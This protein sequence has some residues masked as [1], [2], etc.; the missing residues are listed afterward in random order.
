MIIGLDFDNTIV[1]YDEAIARLADELL[2]LPETVPRTKLGVREHF[3]DRGREDEWTAF[4][5]VLYGPGM[6]HAQPFAGCLETLKGLTAK[7]YSLSIV[8]HRSARPY[9]GPAYDLHDYARNWVSRH[10]LEDGLI[11]ADAVFFH[12]TRE[13][14]VAQIGQLGCVLFLDDLPE[15]F[16][17]PGFPHATQPILFDP[18]ERAKP[19]GHYWVA[20]DWRTLPSLVDRLQP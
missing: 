12:E 13:Q 6:Q 4:Q 15:V 16:A 1:C 14:K 3:R 2:N 9:A 8:S 7:G 18:E 19:D 17:E 5:G 11:K 10:L 20:H